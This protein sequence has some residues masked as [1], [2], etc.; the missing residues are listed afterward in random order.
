MTDAD[1]ESWEGRERGGG[2]GGGGEGVR[3]T[4][5]TS[6]DIE[7]KAAHLAGVDDSEGIEDD[8]CG[9]LRA[10]AG[11]RP[12]AA[13]LCMEA[14]TMSTFCSRYSSP[15][16]PD[17]AALLVSARSTASWTCMII[18]YLLRA[19]ILLQISTDMRQLEKISKALMKLAMACC[20]ARHPEFSR[21]TH[22]QSHLQYS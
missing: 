20:N 14:S 7:G 4:R 6:S 3:H 21:V 17:P 16:G 9:T 15:L 8:R 12:E 19:H 11:E 22:A 10:A 1:S 2:G 18:H 5:S 13:R